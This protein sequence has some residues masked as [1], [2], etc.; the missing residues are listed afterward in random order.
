MK[1][2]G[3]LL[4]DEGAQRAASN[5]EASAP[6]GNGSPVKARPDQRDRNIGAMGASAWRG[7]GLLCRVL[8]AT[9]TFYGQAYECL[10]H[11]GL[12]GLRNLRH[13]IKEFMA[14]YH[15]EYIYQRLV[16]S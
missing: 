16:G 5:N 15:R 14:H 9:A 3:W 2:H 12:F 6:S 1:R 11:V 10:N 13:L 7:M 4:P 8:P